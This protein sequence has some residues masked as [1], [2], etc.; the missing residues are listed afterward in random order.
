MPSELEFPIRGQGVNRRGRRFRTVIAGLAIA[1]SAATQ[2]A[3]AAKAAIAAG[4]L[5][6]NIARVTQALE[7][8]G[9]PLPRALRTS[10]DQA[11]RAGDATRLQQLLDAQVLLQVQ[12]DSANRLQVSRGAGPAELQQAGYTPVLVKIVNGSG[13][14]GRLQIGSPQGGPVY[15]GGSKFTMTRMATLHLLENDNTDGRT[16]RILDLAMFTSAPMAAELSGERVEYAIAQIL[17]TEAGRQQAVISFALADAGSRAETNVTFDV[18]PA[19]AVKL[20]VTDFDGRPTMGRFLF[21]DAQ[22][23]L[24]PPQFKRLAPDLYF[25]K[26]IY[27]ADGE[28]VLLPPGRLT[29]TYGRGPEYREP[30]RTVTIP[31]RETVPGRPVEHEIEVKLE[32]WI[33]PADRGFYSGDPHIHASGCGHYMSPTEGV[34][35]A[36]MFRQVKGEGL[37]FGSVLIWGYNFEHQG[38]YFS[39]DAHPMSEPQTVLKYDLEISNLASASQG[40]LVLLN[41][42][43]Y[44]YP[45]SIGTK[46]WPTW[47][48]PI[49]RWAKDQGGVTGYPH[50]G[51]GVVIEGAAIAK[52]MLGEL[53]ANKD[54]RLDSAEAERGLMP[55]PFA[56]IDVNGDHFLTAAE[57][58]ESANRA[59]DRLPNYAVPEGRGGPAE[60]FVTVALGACDFTCA[61][62]TNRIP[63]LNMWYHM[64]NC[65]LS[66][67]IVGESDFPCMSLTRVGQGR[68]YVQLGRQT[69]LDYKQWC[70]ALAQGR[71]YASD[72]YA[73]AL[74]FTVNG[75]TSGDEIKLAAPGKV[76]VKARVAFSPETPAENP[77]GAVIPAGGRR[78]VGDTIVF[79][80]TKA[81]DPLFQRG[82]RL[83]E[84]VVNGHPVASRE[85]LAD[86]REHVVEFEVPV[87]RSSW[88]AVRQFPQL[89]TNPVN[90]RVAG[91]PIRASRESALWLL[92]CIDMHWRMR[93]RAIAA[94]E[95]AEAL[96]AYDQARAIYRTI[97]E[98]SPSSR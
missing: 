31:R 75:G 62:D 8:L 74:E 47:G 41:L 64:L 73:H 44:T 93:S 15:A 76:N 13:T 5:A 72:G 20:R 66:V 80:E 90:V 1:A 78:M 82:R 23:H 7:K 70:D 61:I 10:L 48:M 16:D 94:K 57:L 22:G 83:V 34:E 36:A 67:R 53:D 19:V 39:P 54:E 29:M 51:G 17:S 59:A 46:L 33:N 3:D 27:R 32:R 4:P 77:Y 84:V 2:G 21:Q 95:K 89:H 9:T 92:G 69:R 26:Q 18:K 50:T 43:D 14:K 65:G 6:E 24:L 35:P 37:N 85:V 71:S 38:T 30:K 52:R 68:T 11:G 63:E 97:A 86:G 81:P 28:T 91:R 58:S 45:G 56:A 49:L 96:G 12:I 79:H 40:H 60:M 55:E 98:E 88:V 42:K 25:Q 87:E